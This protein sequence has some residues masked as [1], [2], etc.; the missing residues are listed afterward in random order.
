MGTKAR[1]HRTPTT[2]CRNGKVLPFLLVIAAVVRGRSK[3][4]IVG[5]YWDQYDASVVCLACLDCC[6]GNSTIA[7]C[8]SHVPSLYEAVPGEPSHESVC[9]NL[10]MAGLLS[11]ALA[12][13]MY[14]RPAA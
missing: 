1:R 7:W 8:H 10:P 2:N 5:E 3:A 4:D 14:L 12:L 9:A 11:C 13:T 6:P